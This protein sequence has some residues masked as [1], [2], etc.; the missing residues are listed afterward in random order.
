MW[1]RDQIR[2]FQARLMQWYRR[3]R[4]DLPWRDHP[5]PYNVWISEIML[6]QTQVTSALAFY[7]RFLNHFPDVQTLA[8]STETEVL[9]EWAGL[10]YYSRARNLHRTAKIIVEKFGGQFPD[11]QSEAEKLPGIGR[12]TAGAIL[13]I[14]FNKPSPVV[15]G[16]VRRVINRLHAIKKP[17]PEQFYWRQAE[18]WT[19]RKH[20]GTPAHPRCD[21]CPVRFHCKA[22]PYGSQHR[23]PGRRAHHA[24]D[25]VELVMLVFKRKDAIF[26]CRK[27]AVGYIPGEWGL[28]T[29]P[30]PKGESA[31]QLAQVMIREVTGGAEEVQTGTRV[32]HSITHRRILCHVFL[33]SGIRSFRKPGTPTDFRWIKLLQLGRH[34]TSSVYRKAIRSALR[35]A[36]L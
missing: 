26:L 33:I 3:H 13:S 20:P 15:D 6:Q 17:A 36:K 28:P 25:K 7:L 16:N 9:A 2:R 32:R 24:P 5:S 30:L 1:N 11:Q 10:G 4:R 34:L 29:R 23:I 21:A 22:F 12:Y 14:A 35:L 27:Q 19:P 31:D 18:A 8:R